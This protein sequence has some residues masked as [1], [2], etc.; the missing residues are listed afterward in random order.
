M[1]ELLPITLTP[2]EKERLCQLETVI[3]NNNFGFRQ[4]CKA[5]YEIK[6]ENLYRQYG[7]FANYI[8]RRWEGISLDVGRSRLYQLADAGE[9]LANLEKSTI[10]D[11]LSL[12]PQNE[13]QARA[14]TKLSP[15]EQALA[16]KETLEITGGRPSA[17]SAE[18][19]VALRLSQPT[20]DRTAKRYI[21]PTATVE[22]LRWEPLSS[23]LLFDVRITYTNKLYHLSLFGWQ[24]EE[25][26]FHVPEDQQ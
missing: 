18:Q 22:N 15:E 2:Q 26:D 6:A 13:A 25:L 11:K 5:L 17:K 1:N 19:V 24:L 16:W 4:V 7:S 20:S 9:V 10:V 3:Q 21:S 8:R 23:S 12:L 14:L